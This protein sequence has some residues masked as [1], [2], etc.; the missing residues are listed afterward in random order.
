MKGWV[1]AAIAGAV[2]AIGLVISGMTDPG[3]VTAFL[4]VTGHWDPTLAFVMAGAI[5]V[6]A[7]LARL[8]RQRA[9]PIFAPTFH[10]PKR[11][12]VEPRLVIG[13]ALFGVGWG[14]SGYCPGPALISLGTA[15]SPVLVF[16]AAM[17]GGIAIARL[18]FK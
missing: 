17:I 18:L 11:T 1:V 4:D 16:V 6:H 12:A 8:V 5:A 2:F 10:L 7:P 9:T 13:A 3:R 15:A 14:L